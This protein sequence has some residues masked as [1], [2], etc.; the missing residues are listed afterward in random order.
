MSQRVRKSGSSAMPMQNGADIEHNN[1]AGAK[2]VMAPTLGSLSYLGTSGS[3]IRLDPGAMV[4][5]FNDNAAT[6]WFIAAKD[7]LA[8]AAPSSMATGWPLKQKDYT[9]FTLSTENCIQVSSGV[10]VYLIQDETTFR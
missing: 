10:H 9:V 2:K 1:L 5:I 7:N 6:A 4:A 8:L 3:L